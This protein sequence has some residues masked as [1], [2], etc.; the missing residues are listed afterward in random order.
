METEYVKRIQKS[1]EKPLKT[2]LLSSR[3]SFLKGFMVSRKVEGT[4]SYSSFIIELLLNVH[5]GISKLM[6]ECM[7]KYLSSYNPSTG[8]E[9]KKTKAFARKLAQVLQGHH[10]LHSAL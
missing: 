6:K 7:V 10:P 2:Q 4:S 3:F 9:R 5:G 1:C 8:E